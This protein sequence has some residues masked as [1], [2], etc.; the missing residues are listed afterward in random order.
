MLI[1]DYIYGIVIIFSLI[2]FKSLIDSITNKNK[3]IGKRII[4]IDI[5]CILYLIGL[6]IVSILL[7]INFPFN[8]IIFWGLG[9]L[10]NLLFVI[11]II[12]CLIRSKKMEL[13]IRSNK[14]K[15]TMILLIIMPIITFLF[16]YFRENYFINN[17]NLI[18]VYKSNGNGGFGDGQNFAYAINKNFCKEISIGT[19]F[20]G[21]YMKKFLPQSVIEVNPGYIQNVNYKIED[22]ES[23]RKI[24]IYKD[25]KYIHKEKINPKYFNI[26]LKKVLIITKK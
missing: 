3:Y 6:C 13:N 16:F 21:A 19:E 12:I 2:S 17:S 14:I 10:S 26:V 20:D 9:I 24:L 23:G 4:V 11:S 18:L 25:G 15:I 7:K 8:Q 5:V 1:R 22:D